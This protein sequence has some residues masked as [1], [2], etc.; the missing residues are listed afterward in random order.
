MGAADVPCSLVRVEDPTVLVVAVDDVDAAS[1]VECTDVA[2]C[3]DDDKGTVLV[4]VAADVGVQDPTVLV[5]PVDDVDAASTV[6]CT[7]VGRCDDDDKGTVGA[8][9]DSGVD[10]DAA[11]PSALV[12]ADAVLLRFLF[13][14]FVL[15]SPLQTLA[16]WA[17]FWHFCLAVSC[18]PVPISL[19][20]VHFS[21]TLSPPASST[22]STENLATKPAVFSSWSWSALEG[23]DT[24]L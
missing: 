5:V 18:W 4:R 15:F 9:V 13:L 20:Q 14:R 22:V 1:T 6:E 8:I 7:D 16:C 3:D 21:H 19:P 12:V 17:A 23:V 2:R 11:A 10:V 24:N